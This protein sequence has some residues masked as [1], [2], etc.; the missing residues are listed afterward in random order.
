MLQESGLQI[1]C[2]DDGEFSLTKCSDFG[3]VSIASLTSAAILSDESAELLKKAGD[4]TLGNEA[5]DKVKEVIVEGKKDLGDG[6]DD[7]II[8]NA[9][10]DVDSGKADVD[11]VDA[12]DTLNVESGEVGSK[13]GTLRNETGIENKERDNYEGEKVT[14]PTQQENVSDNK[15]EAVKEMS[16]TD[17]D[18]DDDFVEAQTDISDMSA[19]YGVNS[20]AD[21]SLKCES[22]GEKDN[23]KDDEKSVREKDEP[24]AKQEALSET[25]KV[26]A[27]ETACDVVVRVEE[28]DCA[29][30]D[31]E[32]DR[33][34]ETDDVFDESCLSVGS[35]LRSRINTYGSCI[36]MESDVTYHSESELLDSGY[37][38]EGHYIDGSHAHHSDDN[39]DDTG[40]NIYHKEGERSVGNATESMDMALL[41]QFTEKSDKFKGGKKTKLESEDLDTSVLMKYMDNSNTSGEVNDNSNTSGEVNDKGRLHKQDHIDDE[42]FMS[43]NKTLETCHSTDE[44]LENFTRN[45]VKDVILESVLKYNQELS[46]EKVEVRK[47]SVKSDGYIDITVPRKVLSE[48]ILSKAAPYFS[49]SLSAGHVQVLKSGKIPSSKLENTPVNFMTYQVEGDA[50]I[51]LTSIEEEHK[52]GG[53][54][55]CD[56]DI[57]LVPPVSGYGIYYTGPGHHSALNSEASD[58]EEDPELMAAL[59]DPNAASGLA[60]QLS[61]DINPEFTA[62]PLHLEGDTSDEAGDKEKKTETG[63]EGVEEVLS[64]KVLA[65]S[66]DIQKNKDT[67]L[68]ESTNTLEAKKEYEH[69]MENPPQSEDKTKFEDKTKTDNPVVST[70]ENKADDKRTENIDESVEEMKDGINVHN[71]KSDGT[72]ESVDCQSDVKNEDKVDMRERDK[73][74]NKEECEKSEDIGEGGS[75]GKEERGDEVEKGV[76]MSLDSPGERKSVSGAEGEKG[77]RISAE[78]PSSGSSETGQ[79]SDSASSSARKKSKKK[80]TKKNSKEKEECSV[81]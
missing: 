72:D 26:E 61:L 35:E 68:D 1:V 9:Y 51:V 44:V 55:V 13:T 38:L 54:G 52:A 59:L 28:T 71:R 18:N 15:S 8:G 20:H 6:N 74:L 70:E 79:V 19:E 23:E 32:N 39:L 7:A 63:V 49:R 16:D 56:A 80:S 30:F 58:M 24:E 81:S 50:D 27:E 62:M 31:H 2:S 40:L 42:V 45:Y 67:T 65:Q 3:D 33:K 10:K 25:G 77:A 76:T 57:M 46:D 75:A 5:G 29:V 53:T 12:V 78:F 64:E 37:D 21:E 66:D 36:S 4:G 73:L 11:S 60:A 69:Q 47:R 41:E 34:M 43:M 14:E 17:S 22:F 48:E